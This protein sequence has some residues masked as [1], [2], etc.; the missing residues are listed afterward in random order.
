MKKLSRSALVPYSAQQM[1]DLVND[2]PAYPE[3]LPWCEEAQVLERAEQSVVACMV[4]HLGS[5]RRRVTTR[6]LLDPPRRIELQL[7]EGPFRHFNGCWEFTD[8]PAGDSPGSEVRL[9]LSF[10]VN[11]RVLDLTIGPILS[12]IAD[13]LVHRFCERARQAYG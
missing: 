10:A 9:Q 2:V 13:N 5:I 6:N 8:L 1:F 7:V 11:S 12:R 4:L 3:F